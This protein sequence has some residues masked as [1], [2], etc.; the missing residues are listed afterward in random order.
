VKIGI[1]S[2]GLRNYIAGIGRILLE[3]LG[4]IK[5]HNKEEE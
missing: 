4:E 1:D 5:G 3:F 2:R